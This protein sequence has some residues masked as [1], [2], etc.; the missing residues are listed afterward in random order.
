MVGC[1]CFLSF[2]NNKTKVPFYGMAPLKKNKSTT[3][4]ASAIVKNKHDTMCVNDA[5]YQAD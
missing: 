5:D 2:H 3:L 4:R 1:A